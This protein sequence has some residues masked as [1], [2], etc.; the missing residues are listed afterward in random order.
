M[1][2]SQLSFFLGIEASKSTFCI[3]E[4]TILQ[5][6]C[7]VDD[8]PFVNVILFP[9]ALQSPSTRL[10]VTIHVPTHKKCFSQQL[11]HVSP[12]QFWYTSICWF[13]C[14]ILCNILVFVVVFFVSIGRWFRTQ[15]KVHHAIG[16]ID[17]LVEKILHG[18][19][20]DAH[21]FYHCI[22]CNVGQPLFFFFSLLPSSRKTFP[23]LFF[24]FFFFWSRSDRQYAIL[25]TKQ[26]KKVFI[27]LVLIK[28]LIQC[29]VA[30]LPNSM[31]RHVIRMFRDQYVTNN[32][33][34][35]SFFGSKFTRIEISR[36]IH[37]QIRLQF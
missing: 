9:S 1:P 21:Q 5:T 30:I 32:W 18:T 13:I 25:V 11:I 36:I 35:D 22:G 26:W 37:I 6:T 24:F 19:A 33:T 20:F 3:L 17:K 34:M 4:T 8:K 10:H 12:M 7:H 29:L 2:V 27:R 16:L 28:Q 15:T 14:F 23:I 31:Q